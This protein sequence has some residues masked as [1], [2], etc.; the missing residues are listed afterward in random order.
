AQ[1]TVARLSEQLRR[2][3]DDQAWLENRRIMHLLRDIE[4]SALG[5]RDQA[6]E[7]NTIALDAPNVELNLALD[8]P[9]Y[10]PPLKPRIDA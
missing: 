9:L 8:R 6:P 5:L 10:S 2:Y 1:R 7:G 4:S 3:L